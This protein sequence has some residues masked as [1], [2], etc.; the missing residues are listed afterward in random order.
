[1]LS[2]DKI[3][4]GAKLA[5]NDFAYAGLIHTGEKSVMLSYDKIHTGA[6]LADNDFVYA[7]LIYT[8]REIS[9]VIL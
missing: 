1:M 2:Y 6:K 8:G 3:H 9:H 4:T 5:D 7:G